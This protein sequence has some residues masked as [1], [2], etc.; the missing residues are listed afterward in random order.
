MLHRG[1]KQP[2]F[3]GAFVAP[4]DDANAAFANSAGLAQL[5]GVAFERYQMDVEPPESIDTSSPSK[6]Y[7]F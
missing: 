5:T 2:R 1:G 6:I 7:G 3:G 4:G